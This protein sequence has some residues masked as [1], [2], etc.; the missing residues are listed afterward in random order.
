MSACICIM[1][2]PLMLRFPVGTAQPPAFSFSFTQGNHMRVR[3]AARRRVHADVDQR[4]HCHCCLQPGS[5]IQGSILNPGRCGPGMPPNGHLT[6]Y[7][8]D[9]RRRPPQ[10]MHLPA[11]FAQQK[12]L[13]NPATDFFKTQAERA[14]WLILL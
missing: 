4:H 11:P 13:N 10:C 2:V 12:R 7:T 5:C 3:T 1:W 6:V 14:L 9:M 8:L